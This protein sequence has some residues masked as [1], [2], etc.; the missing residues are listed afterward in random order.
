MKKRLLLDRPYVGDRGQYTFFDDASTD[1]LDSNGNIIETTGGG[2]Y[3]F[4]TDGTNSLYSGFVPT[5]TLTG[6]ENTILG[7]D[8]G[9]STSSNDDN[10]DV[11]FNSIT[12]FISI[13]FN[14]ASASLFDL[15]STNSN[16]ASITSC[17]NVPNFFD[18]SSTLFCII[19]WSAIQ[20]LTN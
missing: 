10:I 7:I 9:A 15:P 19:L 6:T 2:A 4:S 18:S 13:S 11:D 5:G 12:L 1:Y 14:T 3:P 20:Q 17:C 16:S 8:A